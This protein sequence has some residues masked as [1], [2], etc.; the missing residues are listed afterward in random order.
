M[1]QMLNFILLIF[2][3]NGCK[4]ENNTKTNS[5][6]IVINSF[7]ENDS[8][9]YDPFPKQVNKNNE[10]IFLQC[11]NFSD[12]SIVFKYLQ[13]D[14][15]K[16]YIGK[17]KKI[18][19]IPYYSSSKYSIE[20]YPDNS[21]HSGTEILECGYFSIEGEFKSI[22]VGRI[23]N[24]ISVIPNLYWSDRCVMPN[25]LGDTAV[26]WKD[27]KD[28]EQLINNFSKAVK[29]GN[30]KLAESYINLPI[31][32]NDSLYDNMD[33]FWDKQFLGKW[34][35][36]I[37]IISKDIPQYVHFIPLRAENYN[38]KGIFIYQPQNMYI[39]D[40]DTETYTYMTDYDC[41]QF[42][43]YYHEPYEDEYK[44]LPET[45]AIRIMRINGNLKICSF[46]YKLN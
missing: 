33:L 20:I 17:V 25:I 42:F 36:M 2:I 28:V 44:T 30:R 11:L 4:G 10:L 39:S 13:E 41:G 46:I 19:Y 32:F 1:R 5:E 31:A 29:L 24:K 22:E 21:R 15:I 40:D 35:N 3:F 43:A 8:T 14:S 26:F 9:R 23:N 6:L 27:N 45:Y 37:N 7:L 12:T 18:Q 34:E 16:P 38:R